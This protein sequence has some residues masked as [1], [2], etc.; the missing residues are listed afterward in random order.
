METKNGLSVTLNMFTVTSKVFEDSLSLVY[1][2]GAQTVSYSVDV[3][4]TV[5]VD[6]RMH[7]TTVTL[8]VTDKALVDTAA[9]FTP[10]SL[11]V[12]LVV[13]VTAGFTL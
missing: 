10:L 6:T 5:A 3:Y 1:E 13:V 7:D 8:S 11:S 2:Y 12:Y 9:V 4:E